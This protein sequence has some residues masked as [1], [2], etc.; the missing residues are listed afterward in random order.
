MRRVQLSLRYPL[1][2]TATNP[3][4][5]SVLVAILLS[6]LLEMGRHIAVPPLIL[7]T[8]TTVED[9]CLPTS[10]SP[11]HSAHIHPQVVLP[12][13]HPPDPRVR[14]GGAIELPF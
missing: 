11:Y 14:D 2:P 5:D 9:N 8:I 10:L 6:K 4:D 3:A 1:I 12:P 7:A 13:L